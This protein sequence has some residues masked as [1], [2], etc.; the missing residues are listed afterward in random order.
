MQILAL[1]HGVET[2][3]DRKPL[4]LQKLIKKLAQKGQ[5][6]ATKSKTFRPNNELSLRDI[7]GI[8]GVDH[9]TVASRLNKAYKKIQ[10]AVFEVAADPRPFELPIWGD[11]KEIDEEDKMVLRYHV[12]WGLNS[13]QI[14]DILGESETSVDARMEQ[15]ADVLAGQL[16]G[17]PN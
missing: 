9:K 3:H 2:S 17:I 7:A 5:T 12:L 10:D 13:S 1:A 11:L 8:V 14:A 15:I 16:L 4:N 6:L